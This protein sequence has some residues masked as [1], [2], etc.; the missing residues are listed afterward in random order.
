ML[1]FKVEEQVSVIYF[2]KEIL[3]NTWVTFCSLLVLRED[4]HEAHLEA[5]FNPVLK[6]G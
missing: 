2:D 4:S 5:F 3:L 6:K 1:H